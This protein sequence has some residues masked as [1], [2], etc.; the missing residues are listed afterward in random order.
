MKAKILQVGR[1]EKILDSYQLSGWEF[2][3]SGNPADYG[4]GDV[5]GYSYEELLKLSRE[6]SLTF[7]LKE[8][9]QRL[10]EECPNCRGKRE[11][12]FLYRGK[13]NIV[14]CVRCEPV[15]KLLQPL[16]EALGMLEDKP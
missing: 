7:R 15:Y 9:L 8:D 4:K 13:E 1:V 6:N 10:A 12:N 14:P 3:Y 5:L 16:Q 2:A 11:Y